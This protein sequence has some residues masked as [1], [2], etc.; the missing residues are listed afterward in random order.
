MVI[1]SQ[2][3]YTCFPVSYE[4]VLAVNLLTD[5]ILLIDSSRGE[6]KVINLPSHYF[7]RFTGECRDRC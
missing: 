6:N 4:A 7:V 5:I 2:P 1:L 3:N